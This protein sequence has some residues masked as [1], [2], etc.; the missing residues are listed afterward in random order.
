MKRPYTEKQGQYLSFIHRYTKV[1]GYPPSEPE[2]Q[3]HF[4]VSAPTIHQTIV[5]PEDQMPAAARPSTKPPYTAKQGQYL[6]FIQHYT[7]VHRHPPAESDIQMYFGVT[8][9]SVHLMIVKLTE[10]GFIAR[11]PYTPRSIRVLL[12]LDQLPALE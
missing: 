2:L 10:R 5:L 6:A 9:P 8:A 4:G 3:R 7:K 11:I 12:P 1:H